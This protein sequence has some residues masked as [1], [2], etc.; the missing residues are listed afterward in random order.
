MNAIIPTKNDDYVYNRV[1]NNIER[2]NRAEI[3]AGLSNGEVKLNHKSRKRI[4]EA[5]KKA[6][7]GKY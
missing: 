2:N 5:K 4:R 7:P 6:R 1:K 3:D